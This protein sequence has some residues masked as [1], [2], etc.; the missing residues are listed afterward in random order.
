MTAASPAAQH[1]APS[2]YETALAKVRIA[3][4]VENFVESLD[5]KQA[6]VQ[7]LS[8]SDPDY[9]LLEAEDTDL[10]KIATTLLN[11]PDVQ[12]LINARLTMEVQRQRLVNAQWV[13]QQA[14]VVHNKCMQVET[15]KDRDG[16]P[17]TGPFQP[18][19]A[20]RAL[21]L[22]GKH[23]DIQAFKEVIEIES[24]P[25][26]ANALAMARKRAEGTRVTIDQE[27]QDDE[28]EQST[29]M[30]LGY[31]DA[32]APTQQDVPEDFLE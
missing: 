5:G 11:T 32:E 14:V 8:A 30:S 20:L 19:A 27:A 10:Q 9:L 12:E 29:A 2:S 23:V 15:I 16:D 24:G 7:A 17:I 13:L 18:I 3:T 6:V 31:G 25:N 28:H 4:F 21:D 22:I 26:L 1:R